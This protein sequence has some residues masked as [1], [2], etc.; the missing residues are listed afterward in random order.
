MPNSDDQEPRPTQEVP[1][2]AYSGGNYII[3]TASQ[4]RHWIVPMKAFWQQ[5]DQTS[6]PIAL[7]T[8]AVSAVEG[9]APLV[10]PD[11]AEAQAIKI[12]VVK[13]DIHDLTAIRDGNFPNHISIPRG[14]KPWAL[15]RSYAGAELTDR[16]NKSSWK[17]STVGWGV[18]IAV[19][20]IGL[21]GVIVSVIF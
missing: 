4:I 6:T 7:A 10:V 17:K 18:L 9:L 1:P 16:Q 20:L 19:A 13:Q 3:P 5:Q 8:S 14:E 21:G 11:P 15:A 2:S 12:E